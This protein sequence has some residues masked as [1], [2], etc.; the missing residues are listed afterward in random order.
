[1]GIAYAVWA[2]VGTTLIVLLG[3]VLFRQA[4]NPG[5]VIGILL[6]VAGVGIID[7]STSGC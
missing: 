1:L 5:A 6:I 2:G 7:L 4:L 3:C